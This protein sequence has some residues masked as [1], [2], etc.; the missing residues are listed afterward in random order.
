MAALLIMIVTQVTLRYAFGQTNTAMEDSLWYLFAM[1]LV[2]GLSFTMTED[3]HVRVDF[4]YQKY[5]DKTKRIINLISIT[6]FL[7]PLYSFLLWHGWDFA[8]K[9][10]SRG[11]SSPNPGGMPWLWLVKGLLPISC[12]LLLLESFARIILIITDKRRKDAPIH[13]GS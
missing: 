13:N 2:M 3:G 8:A 12:L 11:E 9:S 1:T 7:I 10:F 6:L 4:L 5:S